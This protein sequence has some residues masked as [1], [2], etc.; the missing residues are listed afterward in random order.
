MSKAQK[1]S[2]I[3]STS[4]SSARPPV[5]VPEHEMIRRIGGGASGKVWLARN[6]LGPGALSRLCALGAWPAADIH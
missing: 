6:A 2:G 5:F 4:P 1:F 3:E